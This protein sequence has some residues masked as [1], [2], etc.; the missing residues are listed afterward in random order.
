MTFDNWEAKNQKYQLQHVHFYWIGKFSR[1]TISSITFKSFSITVMKFNRSFIHHSKVFYK[2]FERSFST[3]ASTFLFEPFRTLNQLFMFL[4]I[5]SSFTISWKMSHS[6]PMAT[7]RIHHI[8]ITFPWIC[9]KK[10]NKKNITEQNL[11]WFIYGYFQILI[12]YVIL[13][14]N[15]TYSVYHVLKF[16]EVLRLT[17]LHVSPHSVSKKNRHRNMTIK[18]EI[19]VSLQ[20]FRQTSIA[21]VFV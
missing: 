20:S 17:L 3:K 18:L 12:Y 13:Y 8:R 7:T 6:M 10:G 1:N 21:F 4:Q 5:S 19:E 9:T 2:I 11:K 16:S 15:P 14:E